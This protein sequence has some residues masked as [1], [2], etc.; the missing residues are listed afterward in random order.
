MQQVA[1][2]ILVQRTFINSVIPFLFQANIAV[3]FIVILNIYAGNVLWTRE[4][5]ENLL[6]IQ[7]LSWVVTHYKDLGM[8]RRETKKVVS[9]WGMEWARYMEE[10]LYLAFESGNKIPAHLRSIKIMQ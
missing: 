3:L 10:K 9:E 4:I 7:D 6:E 1:S 2:I 5:R 8:D